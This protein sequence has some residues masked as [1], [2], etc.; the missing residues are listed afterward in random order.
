MDPFYE[1]LCKRCDKAGLYIGI[2]VG[3]HPYV[4]GKGGVSRRLA[5]LQVRKPGAHELLA[6]ALLTD[7][8]TGETDTIEC[9][10]QVVLQ[11]LDDLA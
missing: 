6:F 9:A 2:T 4:S 10:A 3:D 11:Q 7:P 8:Q 1:L 5:E